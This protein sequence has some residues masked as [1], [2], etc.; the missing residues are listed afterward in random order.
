MA[1][2]QQRGAFLQPDQGAHRVDGGAAFVALPKHVVED[3]ERYRAVVAGPHDVREERGQ[4]EIALTGEDPVV[5]AP[6][7]H[8]HAQQRRIRQLHEED[9]L[10]VN[11][12]DRGRIPVA[13]EN[14][15]TVE[16]GAD[17]GVVGEVHDALG[18]FEIVDVFAPGEG[19]VG[20][21]N[22]V[23]GGHLA[24]LLQLRGRDLVVVD[25]G[26][27]HVA[28][29]QDRVDAEPVHEGELAGSPAQVGL[30]QGFADPVEVP[31]GLV[32]VQGQAEVPGQ[33]TDVFGA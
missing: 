20:D 8:V 21:L 7:E 23:V 5:P 1:R 16:A 31:E 27:A 6:G 22:A 11:G 29:D 25:G 14:V 10:S 12:F 3:F 15:K 17:R 9:L 28:A 18:A 13:A 26:G 19:L 30:Q 33:G 32:E 24:Q 4:V 2:Q